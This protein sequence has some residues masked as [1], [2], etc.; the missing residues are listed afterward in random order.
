MKFIQIGPGLDS[1]LILT[2]GFTDWLRPDSAVNIYQSCSIIQ[3]GIVYAGCCRPGTG[4]GLERI[5]NT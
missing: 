4:G 2:T 5:A 3:A 1:W